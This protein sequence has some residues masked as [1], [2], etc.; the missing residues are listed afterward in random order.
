MNHL[1]NLILLLLF[2]NLLFSQNEKLVVEGAIVIMD[3]DDPAPVA[4]TI[5]WDGNDFLGYDGSVWKSLTCCSNV[6][7][8]DC[9]GN[10]YDTIHIGSQIWLKDNLKATCFNDG[11]PITWANMSQDWST[12]SPLN[13][14]VPVGA[15]AGYM[16]GNQQ[17]AIYN[18]HV[19]STANNGGLN[20]CPVGWHV[21]MD[22]EYEALILHL[23]PTAS[24]GG[25]SNNDAGGELKTTGHLDDASGP[26]EFPNIGATNLTNF[27]GEP[28]YSKT[29][30]LNIGN[31]TY[32]TQDQNATGIS[33]N[34]GIGAY[35][36]TLTHD[37]ENMRRANTDA[38]AFAYPIRCI[39]D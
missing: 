9:D 37:E 39:K 15:H 5:K 4:G 6:M 21:P 1:I 13:S 10:V 20:V 32:W 27:S 2:T 29:G 18:W 23:D 38:N 31:V 3:N 12:L 17:G 36:R 24:G 28:T 26:W 14:T 33:P 30:A 35:G 25:L 11:T 34:L 19:A 7:P 8:T 22:A 16:A